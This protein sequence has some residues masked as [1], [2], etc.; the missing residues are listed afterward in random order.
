M[1]EKTGRKADSAE[2]ENDMR[3]ARGTSNERRFTCEEWLTKNQIKI[4]FSRL[5]A[6][7]RKNIVGLSIKQQED[8]DCL[9][10]ERA[11]LKQSLTKSV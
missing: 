5:A 3:D 7:R 1:V 6:S 9:E 4:F 10:P 11:S 8:V 2:V